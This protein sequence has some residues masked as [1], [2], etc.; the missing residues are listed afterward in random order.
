[1]HSDHSSVPAP[2]SAPTARIDAVRHGAA[3]LL[4]AAALL[5][6]LARPAAADVLPDEL[7]GC[8]PVLEARGLPRM[9][10]DDVLASI[11]CGNPFTGAD[12]VIIVD[13]EALSAEE[14]L[15]LLADSVSEERCLDEA[16]IELEH[17]L[18]VAGMRLPDEL[19][20][21]MTTAPVLASTDDDAEGSAGGRVLPG[22]DAAADSARGGGIGAAGSDG[23]R[24]DGGRGDG[25]PRDGEQRHGEQRDGEQ[26]GGGHHGGGRGEDGAAGRGHQGGGSR[27]EVGVPGRG[28]HATPAS[29]QAQAP[30]P[31]STERPRGCR[32]SR[33]VPER[34]LLDTRYVARTR[35]ASL[36][37]GDLRLGRPYW[38]VRVLLT[39]L[40]ASQVA[41]CGVGR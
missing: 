23:G 40:A 20:L 32:A 18:E 27:A 16:A 22:D 15:R 36:A 35:S 38:S 5:S 13:G 30:P 9:L 37:S 4:T 41:S 7:C 24:G 12:D 21:R 6:L 28:D 3:V 39:W 14:V 10:V 33:L 25:E 17:W 19:V 11:G 34:A 31:P 2:T 8:G 1:M 29:W 26:R